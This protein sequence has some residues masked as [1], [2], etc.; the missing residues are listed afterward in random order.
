MNIEQHGVTKNAFDEF[1]TSAIIEQRKFK[2]TII[3]YCFINM[4]VEDVIPDIHTIALF[5]IKPKECKP[6]HSL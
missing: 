3:N 5:K 6:S 1:A 2:N 4:T